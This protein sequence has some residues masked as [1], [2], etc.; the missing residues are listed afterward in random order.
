MKLYALTTVREKEALN[1][2]RKPYMADDSRCIGI[3]TELEIANE[4][5][6]ENYGD[7]YEEGYYPWAIIEALESDSVYGIPDKIE[8]YWFEWLVEKE[9]Y[10]A[11]ETPERFKQTIM[12]WS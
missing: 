3:Y 2:Y 6:L 1:R 7:M 12:F 11:I 8:Q 5:V 9:G 4:A 10:Q